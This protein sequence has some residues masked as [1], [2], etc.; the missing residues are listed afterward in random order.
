M[1]HVQ[2]SLGTAL[3]LLASDQALASTIIF[4]QE[5]KTCLGNSGDGE[6]DSEMIPNAN[7]ERSLVGILEIRLVVR[8]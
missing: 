3:L 2:A 8:P 1:R 5:S 4:I 6:H 7:L